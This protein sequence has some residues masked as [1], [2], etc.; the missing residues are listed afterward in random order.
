MF[1]NVFGLLLNSKGLRQRLGKEKESCCLLFP[2]STKR[3][4]KQFPVVV[5]QRRQSLYKKALFCWSKTI[6]FSPFS[7]PSSSSLRK[8]LNNHLN[9]TPVKNI[10]TEAQEYYHK[11][12]IWIKYARFFY[13]LNLPRR[14][15]LAK[16]DDLVVKRLKE[17]QGNFPLQELKPG[18]QPRS[19]NKCT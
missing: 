8:L 3:E 17:T 14:F 5:G 19:Q 1:A 2:S 7:L 15:L 4:L 13:S 10:R 11:K 18:S 16:S 9:N 6:D 12:N